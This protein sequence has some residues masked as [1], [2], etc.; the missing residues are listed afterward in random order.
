VT[1]TRTLDVSGLPAY[2]ISNRAPLWLGQLL[3]T[4][5]E[6]TLFCILIA[7]YFYARLSVDVWPPAGVGALRITSP[8]LGLIPLALSAIGSYAASEGAKRNSR[9]LMLKGLAGNLVLALCFLAF[10]FLEWRTFNF[11]WSSD[12]HGTLVWTILFLHTF[13]VIGDLIMT[14]VLIGILTFRKYGPRER[15]GVHVDS[16]LWYFLVLI[17]FPLY[18]VIYWGPRLMSSR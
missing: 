9:S 4:A 8:T 11:T 15:L 12:I 5:I 10:R 2:E 17:W 1:P 13:D 7:M 14:A 18:V 3:M 16:V 6:G